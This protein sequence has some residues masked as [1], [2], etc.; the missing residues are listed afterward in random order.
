MVQD[1]PFPLEPSGGP[2]LG[3]QGR[4]QRRLPVRQTVAVPGRSTP[5]PLRSSIP[6]QRSSVV[7]LDLLYVSVV[8]MSECPTISL[9]FSM[10][11]LSSS[12]SVTKVALKL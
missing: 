7:L 11:T 12:K 8:L 10:G 1:I 6:P 4:G 5:R 3:S 9:T 2:S